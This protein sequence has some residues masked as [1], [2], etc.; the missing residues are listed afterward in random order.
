MLNWAAKP[1]PNRAPEKLLPDGNPLK[2]MSAPKVP[3]SPERFA[4]T[5]QIALF[6]RQWLQIARR[7]RRETQS[8]RYARL[9]ALLLRV[10]VQTGCRPGEACKAQWG[11]VKWDAG[12][13]SAGHTFAK[14]ILPPERWKAG[15]KTGKS[16]TIRL[17]PIL[18]RALR[19][20]YERPDRDPTYLFTHI[21]RAQTR[22]GEK[23]IPWT[24]AALCSRIRKVRRNAIAN[25][26]KLIDE[27]PNRVVA[28]LFRHSAASRALMRGM[29]PTTTATLLGTSA[30]MLKKHYGHLLEGHLD[31]AAE[32][33]AGARRAK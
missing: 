8:A 29:D 33:L 13:T 22:N 18:T 4:K 2:G 31:A 5:E 16:R 24:A 9:T 10:V 17:T 30:E 11:D 14:I 15:R 28:Y 19:R 32:T 23:T 20:E 25:G 21:N 12:R 6:L 27:G 26:V 3:D 7:V 1:E